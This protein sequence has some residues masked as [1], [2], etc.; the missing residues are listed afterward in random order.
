[1]AQERHPRNIFFLSFPS[2]EEGGGVPFGGVGTEL[3]PKSFLCL[4]SSCFIQGCNFNL[5]RTRPSG[6]YCP[7]GSALSFVG[8]A[9][10]N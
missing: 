6:K 3:I 1:M 7:M 8:K 9:A 5:L 10:A 4:N 2:C